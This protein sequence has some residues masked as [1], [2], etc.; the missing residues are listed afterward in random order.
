MVNGIFL[1]KDFRFY[2]KEEKNDPEILK[3]LAS[4]A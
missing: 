4:L 2:K 3:K 1:L